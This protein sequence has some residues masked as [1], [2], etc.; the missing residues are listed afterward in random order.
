MNRRLLIIVLMAC[1][2][3]LG[4][5]AQQGTFRFAQLTD[6]HLTPNNPNPT[7]DLLRSI[8]QINA[9]D[10]IDFVLVT[11]DLTEEGDRATME[12]VKSCLD[13]LKVPYHVALGNHETKWSD[14]G[15][16][17]FGEIFGGERFE[18]EHKGFLFLG[19]NSGPLM[20]MA[21]GHVVPQ[22]IRWMTEEMEKN[23][24]DKPVIL[25]THYPLMDG[26]VDNWYEVTDAVRPYNVRLFIGGHYH[27]N[28]DLRY[29]GIG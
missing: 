27:S 11:G 23:G 10:S 16:T 24:K 6:I 4:M 22:D 17:A 2:L 9:T 15:C 5:Q 13:L 14:S 19:F 28:R 21:Y 18:F 20:R 8:A 25:V 7:E 1:L 26:D 12:K 3:P 29:D